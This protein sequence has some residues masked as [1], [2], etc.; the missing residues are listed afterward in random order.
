MKERKQDV[1][2]LSQAVIY[3]RVSSSK[4]KQKGDGLASQRTRCEDF[5]RYK[6]LDVIEV[7]ED[8]ASGGLIDRPGIQ[9]M[10]KFIRSRRKQKTAVIIDDISRLARDLNAHWT[11]RD[12]ISRANGLLLSPSVEFGED[13]ASVL[14]ENLLASVAQNH[15]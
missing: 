2:S 3:V 14:L 10:L 11:L 4:Q 7:F 6:G 12:A 5:A 1:T 8:D 13:S 9:A 15:K